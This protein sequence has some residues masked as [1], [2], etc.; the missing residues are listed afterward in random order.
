MKT[1]RNI[2]R[3]GHIL[4][5]LRRIEYSTKDL[6]YDDYLENWEKQDAIVRN[7]EII[8]EASRQIDTAFKEKFPDV[9]WR[10]AT[11]MR[12]VLIHEYF[13]VNYDEVWITLKEILP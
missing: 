6:S 4:E 9:E 11:A 12:N 5:S 10:K 7:M 13:D 2:L 3:L 8:G 1:D